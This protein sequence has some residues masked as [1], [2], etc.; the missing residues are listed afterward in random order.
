MKM[1]S[2]IM[3]LKLLIALNVGISYIQLS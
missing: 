3:N 2:M 1:I